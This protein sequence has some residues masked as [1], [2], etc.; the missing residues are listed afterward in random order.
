[1]QNADSNV[2][3]LD[4]HH[5]H[6]G[7]FYT[8]NFCVS[9]LSINGNNS[10]FFLISNERKWAKKIDEYLNREYTILVDG[11]LWKYGKA[12]VK[13][14]GDVEIKKNHFT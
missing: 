4:K 3:A 7:F 14:N 11:Q 10:L 2:N 9:L 1:M 12:F 5:M 6:Q 13:K 8:M